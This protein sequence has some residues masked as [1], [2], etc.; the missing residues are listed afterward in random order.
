[1]ALKCLITEN[2]HPILQTLLR[3]EGIQ[4]DVAEDST[5]DSVLS[6]IDKYDILIVNSKI[7]IDKNFIDVAKNLKFIGRVGSGMEIIDVPYCKEKGVYVC[8]APEGNCDSV[9][10]HTLGLLLSVLNNI[11]K[12]DREI[13]AGVWKREEN[14]G[15][16]IQGKTVAIIGYG[17]TGKAFARILGGF[18]CTVFAYDIQQVSNPYAHVQMTA[19]SE[20]L[21]HADIVS[22]HVP[23]TP[24]TR[25]M[26]NEV[27]FNSFKKPIYFINTSRGPICN[28]E[29]LI[30]AI[31]SKKLRGVG[32]DVFDN[33]KPNTFSTAEKVVFYELCNLENVVMTPHIAGWT[34]QSRL[35]LA[36]IVAEK[37]INAIKSRN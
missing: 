35:K 28:T 19:W 12:S 9:G 22:M 26:A 30:K 4:C 7:H 1:M 13:R 3:A 33:E 20:L 18:N 37:I 17:H 11:T 32:L 5:T 14:R 27:F 21:E 23:L 29:D 36:E 16:T 34:H 10:E 25:N 8:S 6:V 31:K 15:E 24:D 2:F